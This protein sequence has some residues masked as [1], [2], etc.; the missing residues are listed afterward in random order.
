MKHF[1]P[2]LVCFSCRFSWGYLAED[3]GLSWQTRNWV[4]VVCSGKIDTTHIL[5]AFKHGADGVL[6]LG[7]PEGDCHYQDG[8]YEARKRVYLMQRILESY[9]IEK[10]RLEIRLSVDPEG[11]Q[12]THYVKELSD[13]VAKLGPVKKMIER[14]ESGSAV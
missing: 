12:I 1:K 6:I 2:K 10:E 8:N 9:G 4:P 3:A 13:R 5:S 7:C 14:T 11:K